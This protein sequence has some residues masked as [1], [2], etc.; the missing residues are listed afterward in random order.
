MARKEKHSI[1]IYGPE[2]TAKKTVDNLKNKVASAEADPAVKHA[3][4]NAYFNGVARY[5]TNP[6]RTRVAEEKLAAW[7]EVLETSVAPKFAEEMA[8]A[9]AEYYRKLAK[10]LE[11]STEAEEEYERTFNPI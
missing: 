10:K 7:Y 5:A 6:E 8:K 2:K 3:W 9:K 11:S 1:V 4:E